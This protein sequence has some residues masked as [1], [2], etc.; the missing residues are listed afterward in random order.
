MQ[1]QLCPCKMHDHNDES[2]QVV[3]LTAQMQSGKLAERY[4]QAY[5][6]LEGVI[7]TPLQ[8]SQGTN[9]DNTQRKAP[10]EQIPPAHVL[11]DAVDCG[12]L[13]GVELGH[14]VVSWM[15]NHRTEDTGNVPSSE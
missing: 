14:H 12:V 6:D 3:Q 5:V 15:R 1:R 8:T 2:E 4:L 11:D 10:G 9:H 7:D 13:A